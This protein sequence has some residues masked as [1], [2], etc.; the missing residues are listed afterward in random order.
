MR[1]LLILVF[2]LAGV[3]TR[4]QGNFRPVVLWHGMGDSCCFPFSMG[5]IK[6]VIEKALPGIYVYSIEI[7]SSID[8][9]QTN[10]FFMNVND[11]VKFVCK[12]LSADPN[13]A[14]GFNAV[15]FSQG[16]QFLRAY[17]ERCNFPPVY[18]L[19]TFGGQHQGVYGFPKCPA[20]SSEICEWIRELLAI[21]A[22]V[23]WIQDFLVQA[24]YWHDPFAEDEYKRY[25]VFLPDINNENQKNSTY[26]K[27]LISLN[28]FV[29]TKFTKDTMVQPIESEWFGYY[30]PGSD[31]QVIPL[32]ETQLYK[33]DWIG[34]KTLDEANK[35]AFLSVDGDHLQFSE[36]WFLSSIVGPYLNNTL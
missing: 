27:N 26:K 2:C 17:I 14:M 23:G 36:P 7:G 6:Q 35:L 11:Q 18:N 28:K 4:P 30:K 1:I 34:M 13:L 20:Q 33:E 22:Y 5:H 15:G 8:D 31:T 3:Q 21:G 32:Q 9:D 19:I 10:G 16:G 25:C 12:N 24:E 29:M